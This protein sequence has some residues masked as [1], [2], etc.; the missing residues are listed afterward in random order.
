MNEIDHED[1]Q[2]RLF[3]QS[4]RI[5]VKEWFRALDP[6]TIQSMN[7]FVTIFLDKWDARFEDKG[8]HGKF[9][10]LWKGPYTIRSFFGKNDYF[11]EDAEGR[12]ITTK[13]VNGRFLK[14]YLV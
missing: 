3:A 9:D 4:L 2:M 7:R 13:P 6:D 5:N 11:L 14:H 10:E 12:S 1:V 8:K